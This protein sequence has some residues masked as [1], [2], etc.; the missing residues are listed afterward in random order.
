MTPPKTYT[1]FPFTQ[2]TPLIWNCVFSVS[3][4]GATRPLLLQGI[5]RAGG[6]EILGLLKVIL[7]IFRFFCL[8]VGCAM[9]GSGV[10][11]RKP[12]S[13]SQAV[14]FLGTRGGGG[15]TTTT[16]T[17]V[18]GYDSFSDSRFGSGG[19]TN[20]FRFGFVHTAATL[21][22]R[23]GDFGFGGL[24]A[25]GFGGGG[26]SSASGLNLSLSLLVISANPR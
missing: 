26:G 23:Y 22:S 21:V 5:F 14:K 1:Y 7:E 17:G 12:S 2:K 24:F 13:W 19:G 4:R 15:G 25:L 6:A 11:M 18:G 9:E 3:Q 16:G 10:G 8:G 20:G